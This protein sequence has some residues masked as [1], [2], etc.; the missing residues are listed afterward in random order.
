MNTIQ[1]LIYFTFV[2]TVIALP[3]VSHL[4]DVYRQ[5]VLCAKRIA[6]QYFEEEYPVAVIYPDDTYIDNTLHKLNISHDR[7][8]LVSDIIIKELTSGIS[9]PGIVWYMKESNNGD[10]IN[11]VAHVKP[12]NFIIIFSSNDDMKHKY[13]QLPGLAI[14]YHFQ[15]LLGNRAKV[16]ITVPKMK[17]SLKTEFYKLLSEF[18]VI[19]KVF[20][21]VIISPTSK[22]ILQ[23]SKWKPLLVNELYT[24]FPFQN[25]QQCGNFEPSMVSLPCR[26]GVAC[27]L[28]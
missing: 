23:N 3:D 18:F 25:S 21:V 28:K 15:S 6:S 17:R 13:L 9:R 12:C 26:G 2:I 27:V 8:I 20:N 19:C 5:A 16:I 7:G 10:V 14:L 24:W 11:S 4:P 22:Y 1:T